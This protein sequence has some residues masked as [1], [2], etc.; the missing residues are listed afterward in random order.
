MSYRDPEREER[1]F[2]T[3]VLLSIFITWIGSGYLLW[4]WMTVDN[5]SKGV[6]FVVAWG[7]LGGIAQ[8]IIAPLISIIFIAI[9]APKD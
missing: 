8:K 4:S 3:S 5:F 1:V 6:L 9:F 2:F 7:F